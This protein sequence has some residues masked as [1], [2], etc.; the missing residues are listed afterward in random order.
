MDQ[1]GRAAAALIATSL[2]FG[3]VQLDVSVVNV[4]VRAIGADLGG[5]VSGLQWIVAAYT[6][7]FAS[8]ILGAGALGDRLGAKR[9]YVTGFAVF[10]A[11]SIGCALAPTLGVLIA[12]RVAQG[13]GAAVLVP[14]SLTLL[15]HAY[16][17]PAARARAVGLWAAGASVGVGAGP[18]VG[19]VLTAAVGWR[20]IF[21][22]NVPIGLIGIGLTIRYAAETTRSRDRG[23]DPPGQLA[24]VVT[25]LALSAALVEGG[26]QGFTTPLVLAGFGVAVVAALCFVAVEARTARPMLPLR[27]FRLR[28]FSAAAA[29]GVTINVAFYGLFFVL[30]LYF[31]DERGYSVLAAGLA[32]LPT[33]IAVFAGNLVSGRRSDS[34]RVIMTGALL[35]LVAAAG[36]LVAGHG[37]G[38]ATIVAQLTLLGLGIGLIVPAMTS[39]MLSSVDASRSGVASGTLNTARQSGSVIG[40][41][42]FGSFAA[43]NLVGGLRLALLVSAVLAVGVAMLARLLPA[44]AGDDIDERDDE[45]GDDEATGDG[46]APLEAGCEVAARTRDGR[47]EC[48][49]GGRDADG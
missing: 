25:L 1:S 34:R 14:G 20:A 12:A 19:G 21:L 8:L 32:F 26:R 22:I 4:A 13:I 42:L 33:S 27:L 41:A 35:V 6:L 9:V 30:S 39:A 29:I 45:G 47:E 5:T 11:A 46:D 44:P 7:S 16:P 10:T 18:L 40:V 37:T 31:Q 36:L 23:F 43:G 38:Y 24:A 2:G 3:V 49:S 17:D 15:N 28:S 48:R